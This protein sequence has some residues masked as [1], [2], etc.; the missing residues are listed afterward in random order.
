MQHRRLAPE[1]LD[2]GAEQAI[3]REERAGDEAR[4]LERARA[5]A[6]GDDLKTLLT[7]AD[8]ALYA[9]KAAGRNCVYPVSIRRPA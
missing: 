2:H 4:P 9:A 8:S 6:D 5:L 3:S 1:D 7:R